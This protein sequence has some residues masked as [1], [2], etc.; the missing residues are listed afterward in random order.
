MLHE[1]M[2]KE[3]AEASQSSLNFKVGRC[4]FVIT[5]CI[6]EAKLNSEGKVFDQFVINLD[7]F[8]SD[9]SKLSVRDWTPQYLEW[10]VRQV[11]EATGKIDLYNLQK[12]NADDLIGSAGI[13]DTHKKLVKRNGEEKTYINIKRYLK[14]EK[15]EIKSEENKNSDDLDDDL[16]F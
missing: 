8:D 6:E 11:Y 4:R 15:V 5:N 12:L 1:P 10:K 9:G 7:L 14:K 16:P 3:E 13:C 2:S